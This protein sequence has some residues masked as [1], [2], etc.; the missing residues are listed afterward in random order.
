MLCGSFSLGR[1]YGCDVENIYKG[2]NK[3]LCAFLIRFPR[4]SHFTLRGHFI[5]WRVIISIFVLIYLD[6]IIYRT[7][8]LNI[9]C[10]VLCTIL[11]MCCKKKNIKF[12]IRQLNRNNPF[13]CHP[14]VL[15]KKVK[16]FYKIIFTFV[17]TT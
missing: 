3:H 16:L 11:K 4:D 1:S 8:F 13:K 2:N 14:L 6:N 9:I 17:L 15:R 7:F 12:I 10:R 5:K